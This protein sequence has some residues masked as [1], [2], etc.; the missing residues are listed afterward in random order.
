M[1]LFEQLQQLSETPSSAHGVSWSGD[2]ARILKIP[3]RPVDY[4]AD[5]QKITE[6]LTLPTVACNCVQRW[7]FCLK[8]LN[9]TQVRALSEIRATGGAMILAGTG[10]G[11][12]GISLLAG[13]LT[14]ARR[15]VLLIP[16]NLKDQLL[17]RDIP[18]WS[19]H[20]RIPQ[21]STCNQYD[22]K[23]PVLHVVT[24][25]ELSQ[26]K[27]S[28]LLSNIA[29]DL[30]VADEAHCLKDRKAARTKR[31]LRVFKELE[32]KPKFIALSGTMTSKSIKDYAHLSELALG[33]NTPL[34]THWPTLDQ[35]S[36]A[37]DPLKFNIAPGAL[38]KLCA[39]NETPREGFRRRLV[40]TPGVLATSESAVGTSL[41]IAQQPAEPLPFGLSS[42]LDK[43]RATWQRPDGEELK[44]IIEFHATATQMSCGFFYR[45]VWPP[46][47]D[48][49]LIKRWLAARS[50]YNKEVREKLKRAGAFMDSPGLL[51]DAAQRHVDG[52]KGELPV[53]KSEH[54]R[55]W[56]EVEK[57]I[58]PTTE[59][60]WLSKWLVQNAYN[61][62]QKHPGG[63]VWY[64]HRCFGEELQ[65]LGLKRFGAGD[66]ANIA[67]REH[68]EAI[69][70]GAKKVAICA[71]VRAHGTG[72][73]LQSAFNEN[74]ICNPLSDAAAWEQLI[75]RTHRPGQMEDEVRVYVYRHTKELRESFSTALARARYREE[76]TGN[77]EKLCMASYEF[78]E[79]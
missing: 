1:S 40:E 64:Q 9:D 10:H 63:I 71:S 67:L 57:L 34:P 27:N 77:R 31:F 15:V 66:K 60:V 43:L 12:T 22:P 52:Y 58:E 78:G 55:E 5:R 19:V 62:A 14:G 25:S 50:S 65:K 46:G 54:Y 49:Q 76:T 21:L 8:A 47:C 16:P 30:I 45:W 7:G 38:M 32:S 23:L 18:Q 44:D 28:N 59:A 26:Q 75:A 51:D 39:D 24:Y 48:A 11:K 72:K 35:W 79:A 69:A 41:I 36:A 68:C 13:M 20:F 53:W 74:L 4:I 2:L 61:W 3:R 37:L 6:L 42:E 29:P 73:N 70:L 33:S 56:K 17:K